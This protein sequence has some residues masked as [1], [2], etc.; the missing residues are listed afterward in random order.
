MPKKWIE[1]MKESIRISMGFFTSH[2]M[3]DDYNRRFYT[4]AIEA[5]RALIEEQGTEAERIVNQQKRIDSLWD[6]I[7]IRTPKYKKTESSFHRVGE[8]VCIEA[9]VFLGELTPDEVEVQIFHGRADT[10][11]NIE[12]GSVK[13]MSICSDMGSGRYNYSSSIECDTTGRFGFTVRAVPHGDECDA[14]IP[15]FITWAR[16]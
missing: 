7:E 14:L 2:R 10:D 16:G 1:M 6:K 4:P 5:Y 11:N 3:V 15:G 8:M 12:S 9:E 13:R